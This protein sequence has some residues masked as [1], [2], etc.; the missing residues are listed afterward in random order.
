MKNP[1]NQF[2]LL[3][4]SILVLTLAFLAV[5]TVSCLPQQQVDW[6]D[7][8]DCGPDTNDIIDVVSQVLFTGGNWRD[9]LEKLAVEHG[10]ETVVCM[11]DRLQADWSAPGAAS[12]PERVAALARA[13]T[14]LDEIGTKVE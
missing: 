3:A 2:R 1:L 13:N 12:T 11:V 5:A 10:S 8:A 14:F 7:V 9:K 6:P 4:M